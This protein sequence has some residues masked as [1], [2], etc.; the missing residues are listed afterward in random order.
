MKYKIN[1]E[2]IKT[3][4]DFVSFFDQVFGVKKFFSYGLSINNDLE[5]ENKE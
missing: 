1:Y 3:F 2:K 4:E 5:K